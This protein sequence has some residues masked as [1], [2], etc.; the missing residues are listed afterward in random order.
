MFFFVDY[1]LREFLFSNYCFWIY[2]IFYWL[3][4]HSSHFLLIAETNPNANFPC[5]NV[6]YLIDN[7]AL[8]QV[9]NSHF[10]H[11][12]ESHRKLC[13]L[14]E[15]SEHKKTNGLKLCNVA[16]CQM[17]CITDEETDQRFGFAFWF[18]W[19][20]SRLRIQFIQILSGT[21]APN[22]RIIF[23]SIQ[24]W[25]INH[26]LVFWISLEHFKKKFI[27]QS[28]FTSPNSLFRARKKNRNSSG[29]ILSQNRTNYVQNKNIVTTILRSW[30]FNLWCKI[31]YMPYK[32]IQTKQNRSLSHWRNT[33]IE[34]IE[35]A[36]WWELETAQDEGHR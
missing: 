18:F 21:S 14:F 16:S 7:N 33:R 27:S 29:V 22:A 15:M 32:M 31:N 30:N 23:G 11:L 24:V 20:T 34:K 8:I 17:H 1:Y 9:H 10:P 19:Q 12:F 35:C 28:S 3:W 6:E 5:S 25:N 4:F 13:A 2:I 36:L 26:A